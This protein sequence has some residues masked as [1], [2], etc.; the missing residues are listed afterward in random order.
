MNLHA[1]AG[2][3]VSAI[4]PTQTVSLQTGTTSTTAS[5]GTVTPIYETTTVPAQIQALSGKDLRQIEGLN[6][7]GTLRAIYF[8]GNVT[9]LIRASQSNG[10]LVTFPDSSVWMVAQVLETWGEGLTGG[11]GWCKCV[12][13]AQNGS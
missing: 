8:Y 7:Q 1:I 2:P 11:N 3:I 6:L 13:V 10:S 4:N 9:G 5:D 12:V